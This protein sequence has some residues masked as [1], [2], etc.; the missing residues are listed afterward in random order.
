MTQ[1]EIGKAMDALHN[2]LIEVMRK[3]QSLIND[4][5]SKAGTPAVG[6]AMAFA[7][8]LGAWIRAQDAIPSPERPVIAALAFDKARIFAILNSMG[9]EPEAR[10]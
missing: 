4:D 6:F 7:M 2:D 5:P 1:A 10:Q 3:H 8:A 9:K